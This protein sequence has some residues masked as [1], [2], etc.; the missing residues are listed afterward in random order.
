MKFRFRR[1]RW[2]ALTLAA[3][4]MLPATT[5]AGDFEADKAKLLALENGWNLAQLQRD[6]KALQVLLSDRYVY[7]DYDGTIMNKAQFLEDN[8][9]PEYKPTLVTNEDVQVMIYSNVA[10]VIGKYHTR[11]TYR[12]KPFDHWGRFTD[13][14]VRENNDWRCIATHTSL[15]A[16]K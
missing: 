11:G 2:L 3:F 12:D 4:A 5:Q 1:L 8:K 16:S 14:W 6:S 13:T 7:T 10:I 15:T 9:D